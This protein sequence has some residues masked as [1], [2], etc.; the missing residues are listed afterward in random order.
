MATLLTLVTNPGD[1]RT[2]LVLLG[3]LLHSKQVPSRSCREKFGS[4]ARSK[5]KRNKII[6]TEPS[7]FEAGQKGAMDSL[8]VLEASLVTTALY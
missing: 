1:G 2:S 4:G 7:R 6:S 3:L 8:L 5:E